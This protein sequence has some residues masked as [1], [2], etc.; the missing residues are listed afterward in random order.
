MLTKGYN[1]LGVIAMALAREY[2]KA[3][4]D[5]LTDEQVDALRVIVESMAWPTERVTPEEAAE[6]EEALAE[7]DA[8]KGVK[9][10]DVWKELGI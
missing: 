6:I 3:L 1:G 2:V 5:R 7:I 10:E 4:I 9:A 8:G